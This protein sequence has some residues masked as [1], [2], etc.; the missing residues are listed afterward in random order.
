MDMPAS[1]HDDAEAG[2]EQALE[3]QINAGVCHID[4]KDEVRDYSGK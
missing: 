4:A 1:V 2:D 3:E